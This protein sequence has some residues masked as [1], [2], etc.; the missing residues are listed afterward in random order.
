MNVITTKTVPLAVLI[1]Y[2]KIC[3]A[4]SRHEITLRQKHAVLSLQYMFR[5]IGQRNSF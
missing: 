5:T 4:S 2:K 3:E 1:S